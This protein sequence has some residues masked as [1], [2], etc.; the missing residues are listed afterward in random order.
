[1][2]KTHPGFCQL[3]AEY[4]RLWLNRQFHY[5]CCSCIYQNTS[6]TTVFSHTVCY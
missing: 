3:T 6:K 1:M 5:N 2:T 4:L